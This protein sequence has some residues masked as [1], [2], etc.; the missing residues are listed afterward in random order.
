M[1][2]YRHKA[3][4][5][6]SAGQ[7]GTEFCTVMTANSKPHKVYYGGLLVS[8]EYL[9][10]RPTG[11]KRILWRP[12]GVRR[13]FPMATYWCQKNIYCGDLLVPKNIYYGALLVSQNLYYGV[14]PVSKEQFVAMF[15]SF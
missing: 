8:K 11:V 15:I 3:N 6:A 14:L 7:N 12:T 9:L 13:T 10:W 4:S 5:A 2:S 1:N